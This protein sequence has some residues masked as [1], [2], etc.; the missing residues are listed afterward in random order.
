MEHR[1]DRIDWQQSIN[2]P[3]Y[4]SDGNEIGF[5]S[6]VQTDKIIVTSGPLAPDKFLVPKS[7]IHSFENGTVYLKEDSK[8]VSSN[9]QF[10]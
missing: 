1:P 8:F 2:N 5:I 10:E 3:V 4:T 9:Y 7:S 6:S